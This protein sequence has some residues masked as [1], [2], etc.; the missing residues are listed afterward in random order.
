MV[1]PGSVE[2]KVFSLIGL[3]MRSGSVVS[4]EEAVRRALR[5]RNAH[6]LLL[7]V[8]AGQS[9]IR[10][11]RSWGEKNGLPV[12]SVGYK[13]EWAYL[14]KKPRAVIAVCDRNLAAG[15]IKKLNEKEEKEGENGI[16]ELR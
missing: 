7:A 10:T 9:V 5:R 14:F 3:G 11:F 8:D 4:G 12:Y 2:E 1:Q 6:L 15:I 13:D 16:R